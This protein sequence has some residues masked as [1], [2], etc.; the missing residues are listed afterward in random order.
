MKLNNNIKGIALGALALTFASCSNIEEDDRFIDVEVATAKR[1]VLIEDFTGQRCVNCPT[2]TAIIGDIIEQYGHD[3]IVAV[4][5]YS[6]PFGNNAGGTKPLPLTTDEANHLYEKYKVDAQ[7]SGMIN[8]QGVDPNYESWGATVNAEIQKDAGLN[9]EI[10]PVYDAVARTAQISVTIDAIY[11]VD[12]KLNV[13]LTEDDIVSPQYIPATGKSD[14]NYVHNHVFRKSI[15]NIDGEA[16][17]VGYGLTK[18]FDYSI[19]I[20]DEWVPEN[21]TVVVFVDNAGG[22]M[23]AGKAKLISE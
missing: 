10:V 19:E 18:T 13:W 8:R 22:V 21:M 16:V 12:G 4:G 23:Q 15:T 2:A 6:G 5:L 11:D 3:N 1:C 7:P 17:N 14:P 20:S 9:I